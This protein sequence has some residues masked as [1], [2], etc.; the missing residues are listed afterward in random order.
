MAYLCFGTKGLLYSK[1]NLFQVYRWSS[2]CFVHLLLEG[3]SVIAYEDCEDCLCT[4][5]SSTLSTCSLSMCV[6]LCI[7][8]FVTTAFLCSS[9]RTKSQH[10]I[11]TEYILH[12]DCAGTLFLCLPL[13]FIV[14]EVVVFA[15]LVHKEH[16]YH[17]HAPRTREMQRRTL[18]T[19][20]D[21]FCVDAYSSS[22][23]VVVVVVGHD[24]CATHHPTRFDPRIRLAGWAGDC[25]WAW[26]WF[27]RSE[28]VSDWASSDSSQSENRLEWS[29][30][31]NKSA[32][33]WV[34]G[35]VGKIWNYTKLRKIL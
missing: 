14:F 20:R 11:L 24:C 1:L 4:K 2:S 3:C 35:I 23:R 28:W 32:H 16:G 6:C 33:F 13:W 18:C 25:E 17:A 8:W 34:N 19:T 22:I 30:K 27:V 9:V 12:H 21:V 31:F 29:Y 15:R 10:T 5:S 7:F 26:T